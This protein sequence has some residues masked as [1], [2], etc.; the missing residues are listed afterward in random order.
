MRKSKRYR[1][2]AAKVDK[3]KIALIKALESDDASISAVGAALAEVV[4]IYLAA[5]PASTERLWPIWSA[6]AQ[7]F[8][9]AYRKQILESGDVD[10]VH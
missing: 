4:G 9:R 10:R 2:R 1:E 5:D 6:M 8:M 3:I 7:G